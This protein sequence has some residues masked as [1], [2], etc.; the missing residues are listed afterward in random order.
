MKFLADENFPDTALAE[1]RAG[2]R[3]TDWLAVRGVRTRAREMQAITVNFIDQKPVRL[4]V[5]VAEV[6]PVT[7][8]R[9]IPESSGQ[10]I[11]FGQKQDDIVQF[12]HVF[13][14]LL[15]QFDIAPELRPGDRNR[16]GIRFPDL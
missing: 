6:L 13:T 15:R 5:A 7:A 11:S 9:M 4:N 8:Q 14:A 2:F 3:F 16:H 12:R 1:L 10:R